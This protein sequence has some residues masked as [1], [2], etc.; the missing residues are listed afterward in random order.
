MRALCIGLALF[1]L[2][3]AAQWTIDAEGALVH[4]NNVSNAQRETDILQD[5]ALAARVSLGR[6]FALGLWDAAL[7]AEARGAQH[8]RFSALDRLGLGVGVGV[9]RKL[10]IGLTAPWIGSDA[11]LLEERYDDELRDGTRASLSLT[12]GKRIDERLALSVTAAYDRRSQRHDAPVTPLSGRPFSLQGRS[13]GLRASYSLSE[14]AELIAGVVR[15]HGDVVS[16]T[17]RNAQI[18][19]QSAAIAN[20][21]ALGPDFIAYRLTGARSDAWSLGLSWALGR[22]ASIDGLF[23]RTQTRARGGLDYDGDVYSLAL[24]FRD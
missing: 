8:D 4:D 13:L 15:R 21:P 10:G 20:D 3:A 14:R 11:T 16:S 9:R 7:R 22:R 6:V 24:V 5:R 1:P 2:T 23:T 17:R 18:F 19:A 12:L